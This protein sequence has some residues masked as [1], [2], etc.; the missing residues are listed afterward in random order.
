MFSMVRNI[1]RGQLIYTFEIKI[2]KMG[3][4]SEEKINNWYK[5]QPYLVGC[6]FIPSTAINQLEM[7]QAA[8]FDPETINKELSWA[9]KIG[10]NTIRVFLHDLLWLQDAEGFKQRIH[11][12]LE[13]ANSHGIKTMFVLFDD[14]WF[15]D[16][17]LD[18]QPEPIPGIHNSGWLQSP[19]KA[20]AT[21]STQEQ[22]LKSYVQDIVGT[23]ANDER[24]LLWDV[25]NE[26]GNFFLP[27]L[28][29]PWYKKYP[30]LLIQG[31]K[32]LFLTIPT[33]SLFVNSV[34]W[35]REIN[36]SQ[37]IT[38]GLWFGNRT[39][40]KALVESSDIISFHH[41][42]K[43]NSL[44]Q[45]IKGLKA[46]RRPILCTEFLA[47]NLGSTFQTHLPVFKEEMVGC[48]NWGL[49]SGKTQTIF[50]WEGTVGDTEPAVWYHDIF[51]K[52]GTPY[53]K[54]EIDVFNQLK[55]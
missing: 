16:A 14:C 19:G 26:L 32:H 45:Q 4:W 33:M 47:R 7:W 2:L 46:Y 12:F 23:F 11:Q 43:V 49:V 6:N 10:M 35:I 52:D 42:G 15:S 9:A 40:T 34:K 44:K 18:K 51:R 55:G 30:K 54:E 20:A 48:Y 22:R 37:P 3:R 41:Y 36:P 28:I 39:L 50:T 31:I 8:T 53:S 17:K 25:Y 21:D 29:Q 38:A 13:I 27:I 24:V 1:K 5:Q